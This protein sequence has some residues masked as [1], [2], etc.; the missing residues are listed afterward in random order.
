MR[1]KHGE[2]DLYTDYD[3]YGIN[4]IDLGEPAIKKESKIKIILNCL[5]V[6]IIAVFIMIAIDVV[7]VSKYEKGPYFAIRTQTLHDGG[8]EIYYGLGYKVIKYHEEQG[9]R[10]TKIG[11]W[12]MPYSVE[13]TVISV[14]DLAIEF[15]NTP[16][17]TAEKFAG[18]F[19]KITG[20]INSIKDNTIVLE[21][22]DEAGDY[23]LTV[24]CPM[25]EKYD[26]NQLK[27]ER[28][29]TIL[30]TI[31]DFTLK[32]TTTPNTVNMI[33]CFIK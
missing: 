6:I 16:E 8:T 7:M 19:V 2:Y 9:R 3:K 12:T 25:D 14:L 24:N 27:E 21:Y 30:G 33:N 31:K 10:D 18:E 1:K 5:F 22:K 29:I 13:P 26:F 28:K 15:R 17:K 20:K 32:T 11:P 4:E 23:T